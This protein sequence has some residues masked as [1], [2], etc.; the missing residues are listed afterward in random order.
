MFDGFAHRE[1]DRDQSPSRVDPVRGHFAVRQA[2]IRVYGAETGVIKHKVERLTGPIL[3]QVAEYEGA[4]RSQFLFNETPGRWREVKTRHFPSV[5]GE[6]PG[7]VSGA[8]TG[9]QDAARS[10]KTERRVRGESGNQ[11]GM[12][13]AQIPRGLAHCITN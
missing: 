7:I 8:T 10:S 9:Y 12:G 2:A 5:I 11:F 3:E 13:F 6:S 1:Y 4:L